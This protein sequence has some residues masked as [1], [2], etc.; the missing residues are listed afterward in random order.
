VERDT[1]GRCDI[2]C[3]RG[4]RTRLVCDWRSSLAEIAPY[5]SATVAWNPRELRFEPQF[6]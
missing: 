4:D 3:L 6:G 1:T 5:R 2:T